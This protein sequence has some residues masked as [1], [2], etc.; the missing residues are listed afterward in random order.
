MFCRIVS[1]P[2]AILKIFLPSQVYANLSLKDKYYLATQYYQPP[3]KALSPTYVSNGELRE[4][5]V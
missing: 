4:P 2:G 5:G 3:A 1:T